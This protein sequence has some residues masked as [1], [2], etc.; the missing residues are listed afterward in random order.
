MTATPLIKDQSVVAF[1]SAGGA[2]ADAATV[3]DAIFAE[4]FAALGLRGPD[5]PGDTP[6]GL[7][8]VPAAGGEQPGDGDPVTGDVALFA[9]MMHRAKAGLVAPE[10][11][12]SSN[13]PQ[14][15]D[16]AILGGSEAHLSVLRLI[17]DP[18][19]TDIP[20]DLDKVVAYLARLLKGD[21]SGA[22]AALPG[23]A[24]EGVPLESGA[25]RELGTPL[26]VGVPAETD[27][28]ALAAL[29][30]ELALMQV[31]GRL[32]I[33]VDGALGRISDEIAAY[34]NSI[35]LAVS[36][37]QQTTGRAAP[38]VGAEGATLAQASTGPVITATMA[39]IP[40]E[41]RPLT[42]LGQAATASVN[43]A[44]LLEKP[45]APV[46]PDV[47]G[48]M[49]SQ[50][51]D[52]SVA[53][54]VNNS[55]LKPDALSATAVSGDPLIRIAGLAPG[56]EL[57]GLGGDALREGGT[58]QPASLDAGPK[59]GAV[60]ASLSGPQAGPADQGNMQ[61]AP[62]VPT[63]DRDLMYLDIPKPNV[64][65]AVPLVI[66]ANMKTG[67]MRSLEQAG[68]QLSDQRSGLVPQPLPGSEILGA[69]PT[70]QA[71]AAAARIA[72]GDA[73]A[74]AV[75][76]LK[77]ATAPDH[78]ATGQAASDMAGPPVAQSGTQTPAGSSGAASAVPMAQS[79]GLQPTL[80]V[81]RQGWT[82]TLVQRAAGMVQSGGVLTLKIL[83]QH[84]GQITLKMSEGRRGLDLRIVTE[85]AS[86]AAMLRG[87]ESQISSAFE[88]AGLLLGEFS[89][90]SGKGGGAAF[91]D[92]GDDGDP[93]LAGMTD[94][95]ETDA[96]MISDDTA[97]HSLLN[98]IL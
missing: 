33:M 84:L 75:T 90:N 89:A 77:P 30:V 92:D 56:A 97:Q 40:P 59:Q 91:A 78:R 12:D 29:D 25:V 32:A 13:I 55:T 11:G 62:V 4:I 26:E 36:A 83:P 67:R 60:L 20:V 8:L 35:G 64:V 88:G 9:K 16:V 2:R 93:A 18:D 48:A 19:A 3:G 37:P 54:L 50:K 24:S 43:A 68:G 10:A 51:T 31:D 87:V 74:N 85:V 28:D 38:L 42:V 94:A 71:R 96:G 58:F 72:R 39:V 44:A 7:P 5:R 69:R 57:A 17:G 66:A 82:Q 41:G 76:D 65:S 49:T 46:K 53:P 6:A 23:T 63:A 21:A 73:P 70:D 61:T 81:R 14:A 95:D 98:I 79:S 45:M 80:D 22:D 86:T 52:T 47:S 27:G 34:A 15:V 1:P